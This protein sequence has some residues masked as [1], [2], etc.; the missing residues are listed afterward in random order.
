MPALNVVSVLIAAHS[1][2]CTKSPD[3]FD[4]ANVMIAASWL[5]RLTRCL[6]T[7]SAS[8][9][10]FWLNKEVGR[11]RQPATSLHGFCGSSRHRLPTALPVA[12][13]L[14]TVR[15]LNQLFFLALPNFFS[16]KRARGR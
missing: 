10:L 7:S 1:F 6:P 9:F 16:N 8:L 15:V 5:S 13:V 4:D 2:N 3:F 14:L 12:G 11:L